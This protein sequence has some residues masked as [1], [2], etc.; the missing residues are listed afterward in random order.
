LTIYFQVYPTS[1]RRKG[2]DN[3]VH[4]GHFQVQGEEEEKE[5]KESSSAHCYYDSVNHAIIN[6]IIKLFKIKSR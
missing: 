5:A 6:L 1:A 3:D 4:G 2:E